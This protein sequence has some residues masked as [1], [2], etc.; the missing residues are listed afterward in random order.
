MS[1]L[2]I[3]KLNWSYQKLSLEKLYL[4]GYSFLKANIGKFIL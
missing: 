2:V 1:S 3:P 4:S